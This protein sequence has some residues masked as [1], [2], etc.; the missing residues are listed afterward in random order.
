MASQA[1]DTRVTPADDGGG[2]T[3][4]KFPGPVTAAQLDA[5][6]ASARIYTYLPD[7]TFLVKPNA[8]G[9]AAGAGRDRRGVDRRVPAGL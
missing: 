3:L 1:I 5:L 7:D 6:A 4:V 2:Y 9:A 8:G